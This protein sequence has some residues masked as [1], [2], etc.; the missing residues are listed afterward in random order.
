MVSNYWLDIANE[1]VEK[2]RL[3]AR[4]NDIDKLRRWYQQMT[5]SL[6]AIFVEKYT[7]NPDHESLSSPIGYVHHLRILVGNIN[8][9][10]GVLKAPKKYH[11]HKIYLLFHPKFNP[12]QP[13]F[14]VLHRN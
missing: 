5:S 11:K 1:I 10:E 12:S 4:T 13:F 2:E 7:D 9:I 8:G 6:P 3:L 14:A